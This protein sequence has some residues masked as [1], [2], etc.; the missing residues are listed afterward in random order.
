MINTNKQETYLF[1]SEPKET[2][3]SKLS[4]IN[5]LNPKRTFLINK[6]NININTLQNLNNHL[7]Y[8]ITEIDETVNKR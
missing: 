5:S 6:L 1:E 2:S 7:S 8:L 3:N 4:F